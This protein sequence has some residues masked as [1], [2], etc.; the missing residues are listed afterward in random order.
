MAL[1]RRALVEGLRRNLSVAGDRHEA[2]AGHAG[3]P[4][5]S[6]LRS[7]G[8]RGR[9]TA[10]GRELAQHVLQQSTVAHVLDF[11]RGQQ[12]HLSSS[13]QRERTQTE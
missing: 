5:D 9:R 2:G 11:L 7:G 10:T 1:L 13:V 12:Q 8:L 4:P 6:C 3:R